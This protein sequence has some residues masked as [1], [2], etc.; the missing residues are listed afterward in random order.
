MS[1]GYLLI[2]WM[3]RNYDVNNY[4]GPQSFM[5]LMKSKHYGTGLL[6]NILNTLSMESEKYI[7]HG[8]VRS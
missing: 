4:D 2:S 7:L 6:L 5:C 3:A 8:K 1:D